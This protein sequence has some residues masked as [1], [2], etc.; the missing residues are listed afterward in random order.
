MPPDYSGES[1]WR[2]VRQVIRP[3]NPAAGADWLATVPAGHVW[4][5]LGIS[6]QLTT[7]AAVA[8][9]IPFIALGDGVATF[10]DTPFRDEIAASLSFRYRLFPTA[11][12]IGYESWE[13]APMP[14]VDLMPGWTVGSSTTSLQAADQWL[15]IAINVVDTTVKGGD[16]SIG[17]YPELLI[18]LV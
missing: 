15:N 4:R 9:R 14:E 11:G 18:R 7:S 13:F 12:A 3:A 16:P 8:N 10:W 2:R 6:A 17:D 5:V 1:P